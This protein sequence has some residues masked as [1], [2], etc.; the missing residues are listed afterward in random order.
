MRSAAC[1]GRR[2]SACRTGWRS[3]NRELEPTMTTR[4]ASYGAADLLTRDEIRAFTRASN[5][6]G[7]IAVAWSWTVI[8][9]AFAVTIVWPHPATF[10]LAVIVLGGR[11]LALAVMMHEV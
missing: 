4:E 7:A 3:S 1:C 11:Q 8:A 6:G 5:W 9:A 10:T 2:S